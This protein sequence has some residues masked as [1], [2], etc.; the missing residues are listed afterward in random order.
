MGEIFLKES[1]FSEKLDK[2]LMEQFTFTY[3]DGTAIVTPA[4]DEAETESSGS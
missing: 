2:W 4:E 3:E 1:A